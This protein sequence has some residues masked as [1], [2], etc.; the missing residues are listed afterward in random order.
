MASSADGLNVKYH[1]RSV[2]TLSHSLGT[3]PIVSVCTRRV[4]LTGSTGVYHGVR[5][6]EASPFLVSPVRNRIRSRWSLSANDRARTPPRG[7]GYRVASPIRVGELPIHL[8]NGHMPATGYRAWKAELGEL[9]GHLAG[10]GTCD[11]VVIA[12]GG[13]TSRLQRSSPPSTCGRS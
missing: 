3:A 6:A 11:R 10:L 1:S 13:K 9:S 12:G 7:W 8:V 2:V 5:E 4:R